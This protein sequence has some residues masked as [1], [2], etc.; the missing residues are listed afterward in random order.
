M[1]IKP[2]F[3]G[4]LIFMGLIP[5]KSN[6]GANISKINEKAKQN[7]WVNFSKKSLGSYS[8]LDIL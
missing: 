6:T 3:T 5:E 7:P 2:C 4:L 1:E 8:G